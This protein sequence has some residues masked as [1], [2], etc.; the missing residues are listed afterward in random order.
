MSVLT[1]KSILV[2]AAWVVWAVCYSISVAT[3]A[4]KPD[5]K[6]CLPLQPPPITYSSWSD[7]TNYD[8][9]ETQVADGKAIRITADILNF[10]KPD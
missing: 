9:V 7:D 1:L 3:A 10:D 5:P 8:M 6:A 4:V 2:L